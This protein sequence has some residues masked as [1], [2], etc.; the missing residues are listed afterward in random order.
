[1]GYLSNHNNR[2][3]IYNQV[4]FVI[5][6]GSLFRLFQEI[7]LLL[8]RKSL[9]PYTMAQKITLIGIQYKGSEI[10]MTDQ[11]LLPL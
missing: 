1:M 9:P 4:W 11:I 10:C 5:K 2:V 7:P 3:L 6:G 8:E